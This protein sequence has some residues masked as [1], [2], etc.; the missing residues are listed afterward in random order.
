MDPTFA[1]PQLPAP[2]SAS[3]VVLD[4]LT[5]GG[6]TWSYQPS[7]SSYTMI[8]A[9]SCHCGKVCSALMVFTRKVCSSRGSEYSEWPSWYPA[10]LRKLTSG[11]LPASAAAQ[12]WLRSY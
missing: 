1:A 5:V 10:A 4:W 7:E 3:A 8:T 12:K 11:K 9:D 2:V 6:I